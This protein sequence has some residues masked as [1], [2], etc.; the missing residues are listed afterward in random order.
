[1]LARQFVQAGE[2]ALEF[3]E[4]RRVD[5][6]VGADAFEQQ[7]GLVELDRGGV[8]HRVHPGQARLVFVRSEE[9]RG[10]KECVSTCRARWSPYHSKKKKTKKKTRLRKQHI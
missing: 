10:G 8:E 3:V 5:V 6:E 7:P 1:M 9:R 4:L 2:P